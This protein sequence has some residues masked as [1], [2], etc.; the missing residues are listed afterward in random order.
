VAVRKPKTCHRKIVAHTHV[1]L[2][3][4]TRHIKTCHRKLAVCNRLKILKFDEGSC[5]QNRGVFLSPEKTYLVFVKNATIGPWQESNLCPAIPALTSW[6]VRLLPGTYGC[7]F[8][9]CSW[10]G[11]INVYKFPLDNFHLQDSSSIIQNLDIYP[12][13]PRKQPLDSLVLSKLANFLMK[14]FQRLQFAPASQ[15]ANES[16]LNTIQYNTIQYNTIQYNTIQYNT[17]Q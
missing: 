4:K 12:Y 3:N 2:S 17:A 10:L 16:V 7:I 8:R 5:C 11:L 13:I 15:S 14:Y 6:Q 1:H 9:G